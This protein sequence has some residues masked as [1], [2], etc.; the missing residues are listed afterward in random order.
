MVFKLAVVLMALL[1]IPK[2][3]GVCSC[4]TCSS[5]SFN[6]KDGIKDRTLEGRVVKALTIDD[7]HSECFLK[8]SLDCRCLSFNVCGK[9]CQL[10]ADRQDM[11]NNSLKIRRGC[12]HYDFPRTIVSGEL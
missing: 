8:C 5:S 10:N 3:Y 6:I 9:Q 12:A 7:Y 11:K 1:L 2:E 4:P